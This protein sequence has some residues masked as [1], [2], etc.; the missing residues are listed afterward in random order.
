MFDP[1]FLVNWF[2]SL[3]L[4]HNTSFVMTPT[5][6]RSLF[7]IIVVLWLPP[8]KSSRATEYEIA[9]LAWCLVVGMGVKLTVGFT[10]TSRPGSLRS[11]DSQIRSD[12]GAGKRQVRKSR[13]AI[14]LDSRLADLGFCRAIVPCVTHPSLA[15]THHEKR[16]TSHHCWFVEG[17]G[18]ESTPVEWGPMQGDT[19]DKSPVYRR[20]TKT[21]HHSRLLPIWSCQLSLMVPRRLK[22][23]RIVGGGPSFQRKLENRT[24]TFQLTKEAVRP[25]N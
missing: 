20:Q 24:R 15:G 19:P 12:V 23:D 18:P 1:S 14:M 11:F 3:E 22:S 7:G 5:H 2:L 10:K 25:W 9:S 8:D 6:S 17:V 13:S 4:A 21:P 16:L